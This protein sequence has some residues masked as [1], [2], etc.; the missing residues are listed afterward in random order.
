MNAATGAMPSQANLQPTP[1]QVLGPY[2]PIQQ[3]QVS[4]GDL[5][6]I[7]GRNGRA[8]GDIIEVKGHILNCDG[9]PV[10][11]ARITVWQAN[12][13]GR[14]V[15]PNDCSPAALDENFAGFAQVVSDRHGAYHFITVKPGTY[16]AASD[17]MRPPHIHF[18]VH[19]EFERL[20]TQ[21]Y[22]PGEPL[23]ASDRALAS[24]NRPDLLIA[25][26][27]P[28]EANNRLP[29]FQF[30]IVLRRG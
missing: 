21:M 16:A 14:Y 9:V 15:H 11:G 6:V 7:H 25:K 10:H 1:Q 19:G 5:T 12:T 27:L 29:V 8:Q 3:E 30:N 23:N 2:F 4:A 17:H 28:Q 22:F 18:E 13:F 20:I 24:A 26:R